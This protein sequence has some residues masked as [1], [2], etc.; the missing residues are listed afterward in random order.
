MQQPAGEPTGH[1]HLL[2][3]ER[4]LRQSENCKRNH[5]TWENTGG[6]VSTVSCH[7]VASTR[8]SRPKNQNIDTE[9]IA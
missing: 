7:E 6:H 2:V 3:R 9:P 8:K 5:E 4:G 1:T